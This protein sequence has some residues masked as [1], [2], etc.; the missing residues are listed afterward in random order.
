MTI[1]ITEIHT[2]DLLKQ[3]VNFPYQLYENCPYWVPSIRSNVLNTLYWKKNPAFAYCKAKYWLAYKDGKIAG[4]IAG[5]LNPRFEERFQR[6]YARFGWFDFIDDPEVSAALLRTAEDWAR[7][8]KQEAIHGPLGF[9]N[10]DPEAMLVEGFNETA[11][12]AASYHYPYY[13][14]HLEHAG[15]SKDTD[16][17]EFEIKVPEGKVEKISKLAEIVAK[18]NN[19]HFLNAKNKKELLRFAPQIFEVMEEAYLHYGVTPLTREQ[20]DA[21]IDQYLGIIPPKFVPVVLD[22][23]E[24][25]VAF[26]IAMP[27]LSKAMQQNKGKLFPFGF[28]PVLHAL[29]KN[30]KADLYLIAIRPTYQGMG[31]NSMLMANMLDVFHEMG[32][33]SVE[34]NPELEDNHKVQSQWKHFEARQ[35]K[36]RRI[37]IK[38]FTA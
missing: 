10:L 33:R 38:K 8:E 9:T 20:V 24:R 29:R 2:L 16:Y 21:Y 25:M 18:R 19:L 5:I 23:Q 4:R 13:K 32:I 15:Y 7:S 11:T 3:F 36:R 26:G 28:I 30:D 14:E 27:S 17:V 1:T 31:V 35:H 12:L 34:S 37:F 6:R 22:E